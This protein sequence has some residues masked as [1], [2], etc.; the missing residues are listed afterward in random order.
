M[1]KTKKILQ[2]LEVAGIYSPKSNLFLLIEKA[3]NNQEIYKILNDY[4]YFETSLGYCYYH[5]DLIEIKGLN[6]IDD[7]PLSLNLKV[8]KHLKLFCN[9]SISNLKPSPA[10]YLNYFIEVEYFLIYNFGFGLYYS[11][12]H[13]YYP[14]INIDFFVNSLDLLLNE[15]YDKI[16]YK[17]LRKE[18]KYNLKLDSF[19]G[20]EGDIERILGNYKM[21][22]KTQGLM[23]LGDYHNDN[24]PKPKDTDLILSPNMKSTSKIKN[25]LYTP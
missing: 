16:D 7:N 17:Q 14:Y 5:Q 20:V 24:I 1:K 6:L 12:K 11:N 9:N 3:K 10:T 8:V 13:G 19:K 23:V 18:L 22:A 4:G 2:A 21:F 15:C 25:T